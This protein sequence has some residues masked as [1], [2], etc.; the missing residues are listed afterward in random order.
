MN[1]NLLVE[2]YSK[3]VTEFETFQ[4]YF[5]HC[6]V[7]I[8]GFMCKGF[9]QHRRMLHVH[10]TWQ[11]ITS[12]WRWEN[13]LLVWQMSAWPVE[14]NR[15]FW[16]EKNEK[17]I[18]HIH[19]RTYMRDCLHMHTLVV[20]S[21]LRISAFDYWKQIYHVPKLHHRETLIP[22]TLNVLYRNYH[23]Y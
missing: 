14:S 2:E 15:Y 10:D 21:C 13:L 6:L 5:F 20:L 17:A 1:K 12:I 7:I 19:A 16:V 23:L 3:I 4:K 8:E 9:L 18:L 11:L 22:Q